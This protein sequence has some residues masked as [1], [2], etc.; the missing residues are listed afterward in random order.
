LRGIGSARFR[1]FTLNSKNE[2]RTRN[3]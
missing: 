3:G 2:I 1:F